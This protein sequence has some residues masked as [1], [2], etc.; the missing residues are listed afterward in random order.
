M[1]VDESL[2]KLAKDAVD[3]WGLDL[4]MILLME[5]CAELIQACSKYQRIRN[6]GEPTEKTNKEA[7]ANI[8]DEIAD[9]FIMLYEIE[10]VLGLENAVNL[11]QLKKTARLKHRLGI[12]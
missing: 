6:G 4:Q 8:A 10:Q 5:E 1:I 11:V 3:K 12:K 2:Q 7:L 9:V